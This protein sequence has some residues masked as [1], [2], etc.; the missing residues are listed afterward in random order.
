MNV[1]VLEILTLGF[2]TPKFFDESN[3]STV[4]RSLVPGVS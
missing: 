1:L 3:K 2:R 4:C